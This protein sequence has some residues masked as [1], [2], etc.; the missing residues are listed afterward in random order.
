MIEI[1]IGVFLGLCLYRVRY[2]LLAIV[3]FLALVIAANAQQEEEEEE[4]EE[5]FSA[6]Q[7]CQALILFGLYSSAALLS[8]RDQ[9]RRDRLLDQWHRDAADS[10]DRECETSQ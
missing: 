10:I 2:G 3:L 5:Q 9:Q 6:E 7:R 8:C 4:E 1:A